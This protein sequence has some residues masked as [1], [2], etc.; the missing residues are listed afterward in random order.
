MAKVYIGIGSNVGNREENV[1]RALTA[2]PSALR[3]FFGAFLPNYN[4]HGEVPAGGLSRPQVELLASSTSAL[5]DCF[6]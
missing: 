2:V 5:N 1:A 4:T 6:Y 3:G